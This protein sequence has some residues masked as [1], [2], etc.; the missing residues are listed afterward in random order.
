MFGAAVHSRP[1]AFEG[2]WREQKIQNI[3]EYIYCMH[4][5]GPYYVN[6][7]DCSPF[8]GWRGAR[9]YL[10]ALR[11]ENPDMARFAAQD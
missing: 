10:F 2:L 11:T 1:S 7:D 8:A 4:V 6:F 9:E 5:D 3:A